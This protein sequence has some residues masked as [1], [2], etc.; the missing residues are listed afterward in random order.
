MNISERILQMPSVYQIIHRARYK[1][2]ELLGISFDTFFVDQLK[3][4]NEIYFMHPFNSS[5]SLNNET[6]SH[7]TNNYELLMINSYFP[8]NK[9]TI[10]T[11]SIDIDT[12]A[13]IYIL[14]KLYSSVPYTEEQ[15][16]IIWKLD[17]SSR[18]LMVNKLGSI[19][20]Y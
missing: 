18:G 16:N 13:W 11:D 2:Y 20:V 19:Y 10:S 3:N 4:Y 17:E 5:I 6:F 1:Y 9:I 8:Y 14:N 12:L 15:F 7:I